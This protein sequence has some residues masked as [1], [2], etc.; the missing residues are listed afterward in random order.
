[1]N[2]SDIFHPDYDP[3]VENAIGVF[4]GMLECTEQ[5]FIDSCQLLVDS[6]VWLMDKNVGE[7]CLFLLESGNLFLPEYDQIS[8]DGEYMILGT[9]RKNIVH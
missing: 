9:P 6:G 4:Y 7:T 3:I 2:A 5:E 1:M 8:P